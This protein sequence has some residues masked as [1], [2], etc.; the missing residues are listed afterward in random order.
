MLFVVNNEKLIV[1]NSGNHDISKGQFKNFY[2][3]ISNFIVY[4]KGVRCM[5][6]KF[7][8][9]IPPYIK[10]ESHNPRKFKTCLK[11]C[12]YIHYFYLIEEYFQ[13]RAEL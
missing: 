13:Y 5:G 10:K 12:L 1:S 7:D 8:N 4:Q 9:R 3:P 11:H 6:I 2:Q